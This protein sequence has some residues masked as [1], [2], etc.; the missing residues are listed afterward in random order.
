MSRIVAEWAVEWEVWEEAA[1]GWD[2]AEWP[3][4]WF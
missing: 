2:W 1:C 3:Y 4:W